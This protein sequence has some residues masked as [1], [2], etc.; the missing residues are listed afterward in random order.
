MMWL[1]CELPITM[2]IPR[3]RAT[4]LAGINCHPDLPNTLSGL[5]GGGFT[6][7]WCSGAWMLGF[8]KD[9]KNSKSICSYPSAGQFT[10]KKLPF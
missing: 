6:A 10:K 3:N 1:L 8:N 4:F 7:R 9:D 2:V 5:C